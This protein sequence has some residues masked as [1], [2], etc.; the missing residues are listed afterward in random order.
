MYVPTPEEIAEVQRQR[1]VEWATAS[2]PL[3]WWAGHMRMATPFEEHL[4]THRINFL[5]RATRPKE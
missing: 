2:H 3:R 4:A 1:V 5:M